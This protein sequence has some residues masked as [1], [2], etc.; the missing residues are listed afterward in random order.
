MTIGRERGRW[1]YAFCLAVSAILIG[2]SNYTTALLTCEITCL[3]AAAAAAVLVAVAQ[4]SRSDGTA[5][6]AYLRLQ[7]GGFPIAVTGGGNSLPVAVTAEA[8]GVGVGSGFGA[9][10]GKAVGDLISVGTLPRGGLLRG[11]CGCGG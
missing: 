6:P 11:F 4:G 2:G 8:A 1:I 10:G 9:G 5:L 3:A 7:A